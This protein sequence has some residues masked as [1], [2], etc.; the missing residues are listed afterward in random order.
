[1]VI[2]QIMN[3]I[4]FLLFPL[5]LLLL[6]PPGLTGQKAWRYTM[7]GRFFT[8]FYLSNRILGQPFSSWKVLCLRGNGGG[9]VL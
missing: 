8:F 9:G 1:M 2:A 7:D 5:T 4:L 3:M 6:N